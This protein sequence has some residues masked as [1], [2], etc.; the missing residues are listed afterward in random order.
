MFLSEVTDQP[1]LFAAGTTASRGTASHGFDD[2]SN[3][4][5]TALKF[6]FSN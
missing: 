5:G 2:D 6:H 4:S 3:L 1:Y